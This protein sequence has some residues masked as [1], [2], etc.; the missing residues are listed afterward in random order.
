MCSQIFINECKIHK[1]YIVLLPQL[2]TTL[3][4]IK[5]GITPFFILFHQIYFTYLSDV[6][7]KMS[8]HECMLDWSVL[9][10]MYISTKIYEKNG[11]YQK[12]EFQFKN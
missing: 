11:S 7:C 12:Y 2:L 6:H 10:T 9:R 1:A 3:S 5:K 4:E 8:A